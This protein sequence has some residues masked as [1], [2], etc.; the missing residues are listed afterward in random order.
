MQSESIKTLEFLGKPQQCILPIYQRRYSWEKNDECKTLFENL[1]FIGNVE[2]RNSWYLGAIVCQNTGGLLARPVLVLIDGQ[3]RLTTVTILI[4]AVCEYLRKHPNTKL[5][6]V[7]NW[8][9]L[10]KTFVINSEEDG[11]KWYRLLL[12]NEDKEDLKDLIY[13]IS[14]GEDIPKVKGSKVFGNYHWF[15]R[16]LNKNNIHTIY[17]GLRKLEMIH[18]SLGEHDV[19]QNI[20]ETLNS[21]GKSL[22]NIDQIRNY[23]LMGLPKNESEE[24]YYHYWRPM[25]TSFEEKLIS[26]RN[27]FDYFTR[28]YLMFKLGIMIKNENVY[29]KFRIVSDNFENSKTCIME[30]SEFSKYYL[31]IFGDCEKNPRLRKV[32]SDL[33]EIKMRILSPFLLKLYKMLMDK[34]IFED[35]FI[36]IINVLKSYY[37]RRSICGWAGN[38]ALQH[39]A[40]VLIKILDNGG[41]Y[42]EIAEHMCTLKGNARFLSDAQV[43]ETAQLQEYSTYRKL[44]FVLSKLVNHNRSAPIDTSDLK[45]VYLCTNVDNDHYGRLGNLTLE[46]VDLCMDVDSVT[47]EEF[48]EKR[49]KLLIELILKEWEYPIL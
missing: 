35:E 26:N 6:E 48:I 42:Y 20:F 2:H 11:E 39:L 25:E 1:E 40:L 16:N 31:N 33:N 3:Q 17:D 4:C 46:G 47:D 32:F 27:H 28:Y 8:D 7:K 9:S 13:K 45:V 15:K 23:L 22:K 24:L 44:H 14:K 43:K 18:I 38:Q 29:E 36:S 12:N 21:T 41:R 10:L 5:E 49:T 37:L 34:E 30:L 19:A